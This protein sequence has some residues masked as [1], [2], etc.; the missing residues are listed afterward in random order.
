MY[1]LLILYLI[2]CI[3]SILFL[4]SQKLTILSI[5]SI[6]IVLFVYFTGLLILKE[7]ERRTLKEKERK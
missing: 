3:I 1:N 5:I 4:S 2:P 7:L 6:L